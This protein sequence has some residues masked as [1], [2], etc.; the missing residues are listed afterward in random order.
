MASFIPEDKIKEIKNATDIV[1]IISERVILKKSGKNFLGLCPFHAEKTPSFS[2]SPN[3]QIF[4]CFGCGVGGNVFRYLMKIDGLSFPEAVR[5]LGSRY[6]IEIPRKDL[7]PEQKRR[8]TE[9]EKLQAINQT[10]MEHFRA[11][12]VSGETG[13]RALTYLY[14]RG[15]TKTILDDFNIGFAP[16][17]WSRLFNLFMRKGTPAN[18]LEKSGLIIPRKDKSGY[19]DRFRERIIFPI[20]GIGGRVIGFG[21]RVMDDSLPKYLNSPETPLYHKS[22][23]LYGLDRAKDACRQKKVVYLVEGYF[24]L[25]SLHLFGITNAVATLGT[26]LTAEHVRILKGYLGQRGR[27]IL[28]YDSDAAGV[29]AAQRSVRIFRAGFL[30]ARILVL[31]HGYDPDSF[32]MEKG[33][34]AFSKVAEKALGIIPF[35]LERAIE[36]HGLSIDGKLRVLSEIKGSLAALDDRIARRLYAQQVAERIG[37]DEAAVLESVARVAPAE[38]SAGGRRTAKGLPPDSVDRPPVVRGER[39]ERKIISMMIQYPAII[40]QVSQKGL[41]DFFEDKTLRSFGKLILE[42]IK[43]A[44]EPELDLMTDLMMVA[45]NR[46]HRNLLASLAISEEQWDS[47]GCQRLITQFMAARSRQKSDLIQRIKAAEADQDFSLL[48]DLLKEKQFQA[49]RGNK[50][51]DSAGG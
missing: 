37:V 40:D 44:P 41:L 23:S 9:R 13:Q 25:I 16:Q 14:Q 6:G 4:Y 31:P 32:L 5:S 22:Q 20:F 30:E 7:T 27:V 17:G 3:K 21:G 36:K 29:R 42:R 8:I 24:D 10:A 1:Q 50:N 26:S 12:L 18:L 19:Y 28:V 46:E 51:L 47:K 11:M 15:M 34:E 39:L 2:V 33:P 38:V 35:L 49:Q 45:E 48:K 43:L